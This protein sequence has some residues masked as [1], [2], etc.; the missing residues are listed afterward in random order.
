MKKK[1]NITLIIILAILLII[2]IILVK[3][4]Y[5][6]AIDNFVYHHISK[7]INP[8]NTAI[9]KFFS[10][11]GSE[12]FIISLCIL[13]L[14]LSKKKGRGVGFIFILLLTLLENQGL[15]LLIAR[16]RPNINPLVIENN[17]S[18][19][20]GHTMI[21]TVIISLLMFYLWQSKKGSK[22]QKI[23]I[24]SLMIIIALLV[25]LSRIYLGV[26]FFSDIIGGITASILLLSIVYYYYTFKYKVPYFYK[27]NK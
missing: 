16:E 27:N 26:H 4:E 7:L 9:F 18:F 2:E 6:L 10:F 15:K 25:M 20:S 12:I 3:N 19:P 5:F 13:I 23:I 17:Y 24:T 14:I 8:V 1:T 21:I 11:F 22:A